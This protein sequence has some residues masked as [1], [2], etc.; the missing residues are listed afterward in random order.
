[1]LNQFYCIFLGDF[2]CRIWRGSRMFQNFKFCKYF[3]I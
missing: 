2:C 3:K 1:M